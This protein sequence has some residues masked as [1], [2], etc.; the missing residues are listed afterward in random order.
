MT[1]APFLQGAKHAQLGFA[2]CKVEVEIDRA[3][4]SEHGRPRLG[5]EEFR[6]QIKCQM[7]LNGVTLEVQGLPN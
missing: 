1:R 3:R 6:L 7:G 4:R 2:K 5:R